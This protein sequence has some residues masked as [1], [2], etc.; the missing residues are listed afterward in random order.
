[1]QKVILKNE[2][3]TEM[4]HFFKIEDGAS[5]HIGATYRS[6]LNALQQ[7]HDKTLTLN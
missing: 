6:V 1:M 5:R 2:D 4:C 7:R 3:E